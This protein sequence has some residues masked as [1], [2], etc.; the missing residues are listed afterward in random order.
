MK[1]LICPVCKNQFKVSLQYID[2]GVWYFKCPKCGT[3]SDEN[4]HVY[5]NNEEDYYEEENYEE[6]L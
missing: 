5:T 6:A 3:L 4:N 2:D 1:G